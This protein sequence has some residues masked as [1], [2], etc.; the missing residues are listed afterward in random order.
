MFSAIYLYKY[1]RI[2]M[3]SLL[4]KKSPC[5]ANVFFFLEEKR[6]SFIEVYVYNVNISLEPVEAHKYMRTG[7]CCITV[8]AEVTYFCNVCCFFWLLVK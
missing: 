3:R 4:V 1:T 6:S 2:V 5:L 7:F 8:L